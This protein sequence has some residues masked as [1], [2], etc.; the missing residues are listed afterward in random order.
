VFSAVLRLPFLEDFRQQVLLS[1]R[2]LEG[3]AQWI[4]IA[5]AVVAAPLFEEFIFRGLVYRGLRRSFRTSTSVLA[6]AVLFA[7]IHPP[8]SVLPVFVLGIATA[9]SFERTGLLV[10]PIMA[11][12]TYNAVMLAVSLW[13]P[14]GS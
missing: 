5:L 12:A 1:D 4:L 2:G 10:A 13:H 3:E 14:A 11:H 8:P 6:S 9:I 7:I